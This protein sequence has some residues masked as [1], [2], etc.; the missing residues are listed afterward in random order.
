LSTSTAARLIDVVDDRDEPIGTIARGDALREGVNF[1]TTHVFVFNAAGALLL[2][3][4]APT[5][6]R[7]PGRWGSS[8]AAYVYAGES[9]EAAAV[10]RMAEEIGLNEPLTLV[11]AIRIQDNRSVKFVTLFQTKADSVDIHDHEQIAILRYW[12][13][14]EIR[15]ALEQSPELFTPTFQHLY[16]TLL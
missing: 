9:Y 8:V 2:Q 7:Y 10:R 3:Q 4:L 13:Q 5:R 12:T 14:G 11:G 6:E 1:R 15:S 16:L